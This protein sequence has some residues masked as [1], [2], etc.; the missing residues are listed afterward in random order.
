MMARLAA[1]MVLLFKTQFDRPSPFTNLTGHSPDMFPKYLSPAALPAD[2][3][4]FIYENVRIFAF[5]P[6]SCLSTMPMKPSL[7]SDERVRFEY[8][9]PGLRR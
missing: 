3:L 7:A 8:V 4:H 5:Q 9:L 2:K 1:V 6:H